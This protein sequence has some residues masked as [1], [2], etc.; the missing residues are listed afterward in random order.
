MTQSRISSFVSFIK[1][2]GNSIPVNVVAKYK[3][4][5]NK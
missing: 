4:H 5:V 2:T 1:S 3:E